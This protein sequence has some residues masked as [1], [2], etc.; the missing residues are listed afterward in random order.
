LAQ[1]LS[2][3]LDADLP[4]KREDV[5]TVYSILDFEEEFSITI[6]DEVFKYLLNVD[7]S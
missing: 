4:L 6:S 2:G 5:I 7:Y 1:A 3:D